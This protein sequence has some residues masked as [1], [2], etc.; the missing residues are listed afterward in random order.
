[1]TA[2]PKNKHPRSRPGG[3]RVSALY[4]SRRNDHHCFFDKIIELWPY[5][6]VWLTAVHVAVQK[7]QD[8]QLTAVTATRTPRSR[9]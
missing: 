3:P 7:V 8:G 6:Y 1:M 4:M 2:A 9:A 5:A